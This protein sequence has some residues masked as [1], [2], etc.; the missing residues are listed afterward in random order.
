MTYLEDDSRSVT[1]SSITKE[2]SNRSISPAEIEQRDRFC[3]ILKFHPWDFI[4]KY[5]HENWYTVKNYYLSNEKL[6]YK[7]TGNEIILGVRFGEYTKYALID[8][9]I[10]SA[11]HPYQSLE[12]L[13]KLIHALYQL[14]LNEQITLRSSP[15][16]GIH[17]YFFFD[18]PVHSYHLACSMRRVIEE[19]GLEVKP[20]QLEIFPNTKQYANAGEGY[21]LYNGHRLPLQHG[22]YILDDDDFEP[23]SDSLDDF[24]A[25]AESSAKAN[26]ITIIEQRA[27]DD[28]QW[29]KD[30]YRGGFARKQHN[31]WIEN[32]LRRIAEGWTDFGQ[33]NDLLLTI[34]NYGVLK[35]KLKY[36]ELVQYLL[37][38]A[39]S[40]PNYA[41]YCRHQHEIEARCRDV[42]KAARKYWSKYRS[43]PNRDITYA[44]MVEELEQKARERKP[45]QN[46]AKKVEATN[47][48][49]ATV[50]AI[51]EALGELPKNVKQLIELIQ[52]KSRSLFDEGIS[53]NTLRKKHNLKIWHPSH[54]TFKTVQNKNTPSPE[55]ENPP[56]EEQKPE[57]V[58]SE[59]L[60]PDQPTGN[61]SSNRVTPSKVVRKKLKIVQKSKSPETKQDNGYIDL[62]YTL[63]YMKGLCVAFWKLYER[64]AGRIY[65]TQLMKCKNLQLLY[66]NPHRPS[67]SNRVRLKKLV[68]GKRLSSLTEI[69]EF[70]TIESG[71]I[72]EVDLDN[73]HSSLYSHSTDLVMVYIKP[74][75]T[76]GEVWKLGIPVPLRH[77]Q[78]LDPDPTT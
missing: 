55:P 19:A 58:D 78:F 57:V 8:I 18:E 33:T 75:D 32:I 39:T 3:D 35:L 28:Y 27:A 20:G 7:Y 25:R 9:D 34:A 13:R 42:A 45:N 40:A 29:F 50:Q 71:T 12:N 10:N 48:I 68:E 70:R 59:V 65:L 47:K 62:R 4:E 26:D 5:P 11:V 14:G 15:T 16:K 46:E 72:V 66:Q 69:Q 30:K 1:N 37:H 23:I 22:S 43:K 24:I 77:L 2:C 53:E 38:T 51:A 67:I 6:W 31:D 44:Q 21:S 54:R 49:I 63:P 61:D 76:P 41:K 17:C 52:E 74:V 56:Q 73:Y 64:F 60:Q 36:Q